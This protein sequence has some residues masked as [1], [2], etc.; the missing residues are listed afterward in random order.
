MSDIKNSRKYIKKQLKE[1]TPIQE[2]FI[3]NR[4]RKEWAEAERALKRHE[5][6]EKAALA[7]AAIGKGLLAL[8]LV[9]GAITI[10]AVAPN[11][12]A[13]FGRSGIFRKYFRSG[14]LSVELKRGSSRAYWRYRKIGEGEYR[15]SLTS[16]GRQ[17][18]LR[19]EMRKLKLSR[20]PKW[21]G[22]WRVVIFDVSRKH[23]SERAILRRKLEEIGMVRIQD[24]VFVYPYPCTEETM[25]WASLLNI[26]AG[27]QVL[28]SRFLTGT[29]LEKSLRRKFGLY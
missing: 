19:A 9:A 3:V 6:A 21:D 13:A 28:E 8:L 26:S 20:Q 16:E 1:L 12:F 14:K 5:L 18:A 27:V 23:D 10:T 25:F 4:L 15:V 11:V 7:G 22:K 17:A 29:D 2:K 24:S